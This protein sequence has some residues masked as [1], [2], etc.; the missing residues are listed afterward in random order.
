M[1][2]YLKDLLCE[3][4]EALDDE[5]ERFLIQLLTLVRHHLNKKTGKR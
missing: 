5:D 3:M 4:L 1:S 2:N